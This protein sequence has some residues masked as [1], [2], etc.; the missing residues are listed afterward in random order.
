MDAQQLRQRLRLTPPKTA[1]RGD[2]K[3]LPILLGS[4]QALAR[5]CKSIRMVN[6]PDIY[7]RIA[8]RELLQRAE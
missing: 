7:A 4:C 3:I 1:L 8:N 5:A 2:T 6:Q